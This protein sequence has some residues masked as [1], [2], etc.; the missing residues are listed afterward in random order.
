MDI[1]SLDNKRNAPTN[2]AAKVNGVVE[3]KKP[4]KKAPKEDEVSTFLAKNSDDTEKAVESEDETSD[5]EEITEE[6][7]L[8]EQNELHKA[9][10]LRDSSEDSDESDSDRRLNGIVD[11]YQLKSTTH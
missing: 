9:Q 7:F 10:L 4:L 2:A 3:S 6:Q 8:K 5:H 11:L 1:K